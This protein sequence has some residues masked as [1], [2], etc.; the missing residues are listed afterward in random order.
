[1]GGMATKQD[2]RFKR[3]SGHA[4]YRTAAT[5]LGSERAAVDAVLTLSESQMTRG[6]TLVM[7]KICSIMSVNDKAMTR[8]TLAG[9]GDNFGAV[10]M[11]K[12]SAL[13]T[14]RT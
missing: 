8:T 12:T 3:V 10:G 1:M 6:M 7:R 4:T 13:T 14:N 9:T 11:N 2:S 5:A